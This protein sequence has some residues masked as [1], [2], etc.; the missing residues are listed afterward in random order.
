MTWLLPSQS[1]RKYHG[2]Y[3]KRIN[4]ISYSRSPSQQLVGNYLGLKRPVHIELND[5]KRYIVDA[6]DL[7]MGNVKLNA[8]W[9]EVHKSSVIRLMT[10]EN[11]THMMEAL[12]VLR[13]YGM[14]KTS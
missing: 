2:M 1:N 5:G 7:D 6:G 9:D 12:H 10:T 8:E 11:Y 14:E 3:P 13:G 4:S